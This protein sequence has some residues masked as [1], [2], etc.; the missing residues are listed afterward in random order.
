MEDLNLKEQKEIYQTYIKR[1]WKWKCMS[2][3]DFFSPRM[4]FFRIIFKDLE[5]DKK[6]LKK[7][8][9]FYHLICRSCATSQQI[10]VI[11]KIDCQF[12]NSKHEITDI[13]KLDQD[14]EV[15]SDC[16]II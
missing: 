2:C 13:K 5:I 8:T 16:L 12:C 9:E 6:L 15:E 3:G 14:N 1:Y 4:E 11:K 10:N 7:K